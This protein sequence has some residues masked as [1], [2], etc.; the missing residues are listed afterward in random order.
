M[1]ATTVLSFFDGFHSHHKTSCGA[2]SL[3]VSFE[4]EDATS[5]KII[6]R[7]PACQKSIRGSIQDADMPRVIQLLDPNRAS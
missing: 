6:L 5:T 4:R 3:D 2:S 7:C 1:D